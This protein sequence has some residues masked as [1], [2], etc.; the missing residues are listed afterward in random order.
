MAI[1]NFAL[2]WCVCI[3]SWSLRPFLE[4]LRAEGA[5]VAAVRLPDRFHPAVSDRPAHCPL[6]GSVVS[7]V[8]IQVWAGVEAAVVKTVLTAQALQRYTRLIEGKPTHHWRTRQ[9]QQSSPL[10]YLVE[11]LQAAEA[12]SWL[13]HRPVWFRRHVRHC[14][15]AVRQA[16]LCSLIWPDWT[17]LHLNSLVV[18]RADMCLRS[19][20]LPL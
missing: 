5:D 20:S 6:S 2:L 15:E 9:Q 18:G 14:T 17:G 4:H 11:P 13:L 19:I 7:A 8:C 10:R 16:Y 1:V 3:C 12:S